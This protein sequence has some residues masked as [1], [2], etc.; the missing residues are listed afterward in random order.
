MDP[1]CGRAGSRVTPSPMPRHPAVRKC[2]C[3]LF[4]PPILLV[5]VTA[6]GGGAG[7]SCCGDVGHKVV[8]KK[9]CGITLFNMCTNR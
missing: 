1:I 2:S 8:G 4:Q 7:R 3:W 5:L 9:T 6:G